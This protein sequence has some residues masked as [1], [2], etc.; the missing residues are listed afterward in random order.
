MKET[1]AIKAITPKFVDRWKYL[2]GLRDWDIKWRY[3]KLEDGTYGEC[4]VEAAH[5]SASIILDIEKH[6]NKQELLNP[7]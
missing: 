4:G 3:S 6:K 1:E 5:K 2:L 7:P